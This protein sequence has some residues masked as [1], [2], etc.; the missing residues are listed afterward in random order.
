MIFG[1]KFKLE[2]TYDIICVE[3]ASIGNLIDIVGTVSKN[4]SRLMRIRYLVGQNL[5]MSRRP[6]TK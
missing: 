4:P 2:E 5:G 3:Y 6:N 1:V